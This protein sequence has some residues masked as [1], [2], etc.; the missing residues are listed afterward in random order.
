MGGFRAL[1]KVRNNSNRARG[2]IQAGDKL[3]RAG[4]AMRIDVHFLDDRR[5]D[6]EKLNAKLHSR[7]LHGI[8]VDV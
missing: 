1:R 4:D 7:T 8:N 2:P 6:V 3:D 5:R